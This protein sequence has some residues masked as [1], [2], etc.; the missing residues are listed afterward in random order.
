MTRKIVMVGDSGVGKTSI[1]ARYTDDF[2]DETISLPTVNAGF[3]KAFAEDDKGQ[4][5]EFDIW[6]TA[7]QEKYRTLTK[8][9]YRDAQ[10]ALIC[11]NFQEP[12]FNDSIDYWAKAVLDQTNNCI[13]YLVA[14]KSDLLEDKEDLENFLK[15]K[16]GNMFT[17]TFITSSK[18]NENITDLFKTMANQNVRHIPNKQPLPRK[19]E[20]TPENKCC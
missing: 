16:Q 12:G 2:F 5:I 14:T 1:L 18:S 8:L 11:F 15:E 3:Q 17:Q 19:P 9:Y 13:L 6:D 7:G 20:D 4:N 10:I